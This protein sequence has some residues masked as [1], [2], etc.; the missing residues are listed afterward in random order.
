M[1]ATIVPVGS[2]LRCQAGIAVGSRIARAPLRPS[3]A[4]F[5]SLI[6]SRASFGVNGRHATAH[7][8]IVCSARTSMEVGWFSN[9]FYTVQIAYYQLVVS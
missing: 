9:S 8:L 6:S 2:R 7:Q 5:R 3:K 4:H 1:S